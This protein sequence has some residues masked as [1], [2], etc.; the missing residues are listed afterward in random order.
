MDTDRLELKTLVRI[1]AVV[2]A[3]ELAVILIASVVP[4][5]GLVVLGAGRLVQIGLMLYLLSRWDRGG[6]AIGLRQSEI[7]P[8]LKT[9]LIWSA[10]FGLLVAA[11][12]GLMRVMGLNPVH[13]LGGGLSTDSLKIFLY[14]LVGGLV[15]PV[16]EE[17]FFRGMVYGYFRRWGRLLALTASTAF[18]ALAHVPNS[19]IPI[20]QIVG[21]ILFALAFEA[22]RNLMTPI[23][24]HVLGNWAI[25]AVLLTRISQ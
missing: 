3:V 23:T 2:L 9:G 22:T 7:R 15:S 24:I 11:G 1:T 18:F 14:F 13:W 10:G 6:A 21:G 5:S 4:F 12:Y 20:F 16:A 19:G 25:Y 17:I 8:G